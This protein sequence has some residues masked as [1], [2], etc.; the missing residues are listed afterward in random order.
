[1]SNRITDIIFDLDGTLIDSAPSI[2]ICLAATLAEQG[3]KPAVALTNELIGPPL[4][5]TLQKLSN[6]EDTKLLEVMVESFK[7]N[8]DSNGYKETKAFSN[9]TDMLADLQAAD[10]FLHIATNKR[11]K[12]TH[13]ILNHLE[14]NHLF[15]TVYASDSKTPPFASKTEMLSVLI[16][17]ESVLPS[18]AI[19]IGDR[20]D[21]RKAAVDNGLGFIAAGW[22]YRDDGF[23]VS[24]EYFIAVENPADIPHAVEK[25]VSYGH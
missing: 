21:D 10:Y 17:E 16:K 5:T 8:Y 15:K 9:I 20:S 18:Q 13:L 25:D 12:P 11:L 22:G 3:I 4:R 14:W 2:L 7:R 23:L 19:Y 1:M 6:V 24:S